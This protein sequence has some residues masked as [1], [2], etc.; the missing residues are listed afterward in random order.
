MFA[1]LSLE[2]QKEFLTAYYDREKGIGYS[3][4]RTTIHSSDFS[5]G[6]YTY[7]EEGDSALATFNI[8]HDRQVRIPL[9]KGA[10]ET[11]GG[12]LM[13]YASPWSPPPS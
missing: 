7:I 1:R 11:A 8:D 4:M 10:T 12:T 3:L 2:K 9:I 13:L 5:S 6:S